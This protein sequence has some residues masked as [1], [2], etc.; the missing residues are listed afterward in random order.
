MWRRIDID[1]KV[2]W[3]N[4]NLSDEAGSDEEYLTNE[5]FRSV[6]LAPLWN[7]GKGKG[8]G[9]GKKGEFENGNGKGKPSKDK[10]SGGGTGKDV[11]TCDSDEDYSTVNG[12]KYS[13]RYTRCNI[14]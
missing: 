8:K 5:E 11:S 14:E 10:A 7:C 12:H 9:D 2:F 4:L 13:K 6:V 3:R 1:G